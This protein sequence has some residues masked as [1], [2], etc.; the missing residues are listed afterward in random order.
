MCADFSTLAG[1]RHSHGAADSGPP[2][3]LQP[4]ALLAHAVCKVLRAL[5]AAAP[6][7]GPVGQRW[8]LGGSSQGGRAAD[9]AE[10][11]HTCGS[12]RAG[13]C[14]SRAEASHGGEWGDMPCP[15][16]WSLGCCSLSEC[17]IQF[18]TSSRPAPPSHPKDWGVLSGTPQVHTS[19]CT[20]EPPTLLAYGQGIK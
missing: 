16:P 1:V 8:R 20:C 17:S 5:A 7:D 10:A 19:S 13:E 9:G 11:S 15:W 3:Q 4:S 6:P 18:V 14:P 2:P 12:S